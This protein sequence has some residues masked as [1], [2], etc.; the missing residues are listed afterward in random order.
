MLWEILRKHLAYNTLLVYDREF[1]TPW[2]ATS[3]LLYLNQFWRGGAR[4]LAPYPQ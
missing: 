3:S 1:T 2:S 4:P